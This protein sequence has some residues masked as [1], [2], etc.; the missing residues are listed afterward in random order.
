[1]TIWTRLTV[2]CRL[3]D[4]CHTLRQLKVHGHLW[5]REARTAWPDCVR[6]YWEWFAELVGKD[7]SDVGSELYMVPAP[8][9]ISIDR[10]DEAFIWI[11]YVDSTMT[12][13]IVWR[14]ALTKAYRPYGAISATARFTGWHRDTVRKHWRGGLESIATRLNGGSA[15][16]D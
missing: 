12:R 1:M 9:P 10:M 4:A 6:D 8:S 5:P 11:G 7:A 13:R 15:D 14:T 16:N 2:E 3:V